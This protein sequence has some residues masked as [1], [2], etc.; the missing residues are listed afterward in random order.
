MTLATPTDELMDTTPLLGDPA[1]LRAQAQADGFVFLRRLLDP[2]RVWSLRSQIVAILREAGWVLPGDDRQAIRNPRQSAL[3]EAVHPEFF[4]VYDR[5]QRLLPFHALAHDAAL[6]HAV[7]AVLGEK[8]FPHPRNIARV[9]FP[10]SPPT[11]THQDYLHIRGTK[12]T[13]TSWI[14]L[15]EAPRELGGLALLRGGH[16]LG[17]LPV[18]AMPGAGGS[19]I[20][21]QHLGRDIRWLTTDYQP[22]DVLLLH[23]LTPHRSLPNLTADRMRLSVDYRFQPR[24]HPVHPSSLQ[25]HHRRCTWDEIYSHWPDTAEARALRHYWNAWD[26]KVESSD[27]APAGY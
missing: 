15:G 23:S 8:A 12:E 11:P 26:L 14:P 10:D 25:P 3:V 24:S 17:L 7:E 9:L 5:I 20:E 1:A 6:S 13:W 19:G 18:K 27:R 22:G 4:D 2:Q 21:N 16:Q